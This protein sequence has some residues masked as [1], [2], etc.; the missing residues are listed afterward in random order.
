MRAHRRHTHSR[1]LSSEKID[2]RHHRSR[3][4]IGLSAGLAPYLKP[5]AGL[6]TKNEASPRQQRLEKECALA[7][8]TM[9]QG[10][11]VKVAADN[12]VE[13]IVPS[14]L[15]SRP[16]WVDMM[17]VSE[18]SF[19]IMASPTF[20]ADPPHLFCQTRFC[21]P[22]L[23]DGRDLIFDVMP[24]PWG[25]VSFDQII[26]ALPSFID[27]V[28]TCCPAAN[29]SSDP[30]STPATP[31][32]MPLETPKS[33]YTLPPG[34]FRRR[35]PSMLETYIDPVSGLSI[36]PCF[37]CSELQAS[38]E[39]KEKPL[40]FELQWT[41]RRVCRIDRRYLFLSE[42][43]LC[44]IEEVCKK[45]RA[46]S[47]GSEFTDNGTDSLQQAPREKGDVNES[48]T[49]N[50]GRAL[51]RSGT[52]A[53]EAL[54][55]L[56]MCGEVKFWGHLPLLEHVIRRGNEVTFVFGR[57][58][59]SNI[60]EEMMCADKQTLIMEV[61]KTFLRILE[62]HM[63][64]LKC[65]WTT[66]DE[67]EG[68]QRMIREVEFERRQLIVRIP[69]DSAPETLAKKTYTFTMKNTGLPFSR[70]A[71]FDDVRLNGQT[72]CG[73]EE[74]A[75]EGVGRDRDIS[76][77]TLQRPAEDA[78]RSERIMWRMGRRIHK[79]IQPLT[80][81]FQEA[82]ED[83]SRGMSRAIASP[84]RWQLFALGPTLETLSFSII[85][86]NCIAVGLETSLRAQRAQR[87]SDEEN[88]GEDWRE[89]RYWEDVLR[90]IQYCCLASFVVEIAFKLVA[91]GGKYF[92]TDRYNTIDLFILLITV[93]PWVI[94]WIIYRK[95]GGGGEHYATQAWRKLVI[96]RVFRAL[97]LA[98]VLR[99]TAFFKELWMLTSGITYSL[100]TLLWGAFITALLLYVFAV[101]GTTMIAHAPMYR[102]CLQLR[103]EDDPECTNPRKC[104]VLKLK[105]GEDITREEAY[106]REYERDWRVQ[107]HFGTVVQ[108]M[109]TLFGIMTLDDW[110]ET[111][112]EV[113]ETQPWMWLFF[114]SFIAVSVFAL[115]N[116]ITAVLV[117]SATHIAR[118]DEAIEKERAF[119]KLRRTLMRLID[120]F[121]DHGLHAGAPTRSSGTPLTH[122]VDMVSRA[123]LRKVIASPELK[124]LL[125]VYEVH[126]PELALLVEELFDGRSHQTIR[127]DEFIFGVQNLRGPAK[128]KDLLHLMGNINAN[129]EAIIKMHN[130]HKSLLRAQQRQ[131][132]A[133]INEL[134]DTLAV[135]S[136]DTCSIFTSDTLTTPGQ[137][138]T[139]APVR[140][141]S[142][143]RHRSPDSY[144]GC[145]GG[146]NFLDSISS[147]VRTSTET[148]GGG[149]G[150]TTG[151]HRNTTIHRYGGR[152]RRHR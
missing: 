109:K 7:M 10:F 120:D 145:S 129:K 30:P 5:A 63:A 146:G 68:P 86:L 76:I 137:G 18:I 34:F 44:C 84:N 125:K 26:R 58:S 80:T 95:H 124:P 77:I 70:S 134:R 131:V 23:V 139:V 132:M 141:M 138:A 11:D 116:L 85:L 35:L 126:E 118:E 89:H 100:K 8:S 55:H 1:S 47:E 42:G 41:G 106:E 57:S 72:T 110:G 74:T 49:L 135:L 140:A 142:P 61:P 43:A 121:Y 96:L 88:P 66:R 99:H 45:G 2:V 111:V 19:T 56:A 53:L 113:I 150:V 83:G 54:G 75:E 112:E 52:D 82:V 14:L 65:Q 9:A 147:P 51:V 3:T 115:T 97:R 64:K 117:E 123:T 90:I 13:V 20:P 133:S 33:P 148:M 62:A 40:S 79:T 144:G 78:T 143:G 92:F 48:T 114:A 122:D 31:A 38:R 151:G 128:S 60:P 103:D 101:F 94:A 16:L 29:S 87:Q 15:L 73:R 25:S 59:H 28:A 136:R 24:A 130:E 149:R 46:P 108:S 102:D 104:C 152:G 91:L 71:T 27:R 98:R 105:D 119:T 4:T 22:S 37:E 67:T 36:V 69:S 17:P 50:F 12:S 32:P 107:D 21:F 127:V 6:R 81:W 93:P 39:E